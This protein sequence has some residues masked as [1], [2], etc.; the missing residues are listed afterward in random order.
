[1][2]Y[3]KIRLNCPECDH[4][5]DEHLIVMDKLTDIMLASKDLYHLI[6]NGKLEDCHLTKLE[7]ALSRLEEE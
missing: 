2:S 3:T 7:K 5:W 4:V 1:M 6:V